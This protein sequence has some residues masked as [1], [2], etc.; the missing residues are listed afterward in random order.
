MQDRPISWED[1]QMG[2]PIISP[3]IET[4]TTH[5][6]HENCVHPKRSLSQFTIF[7]FTSGAKVQHLTLIMT[8]AF[9]KS[10]ILRGDYDWL[11]DREKILSSV[12]FSDR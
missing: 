10:T 9:C 1:H 3:Q 4:L 12:N 7:I 8:V 6:R 5:L 2:S 11:F